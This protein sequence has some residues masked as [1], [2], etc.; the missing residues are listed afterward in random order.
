MRAV[1]NNLPA[2][3]AP[4]KDR[5]L[6][7]CLWNGASRGKES[8]L[9]DSGW[10]GEISA[11]VGRVRCPAFLSILQRFPHLVQEVAREAEEPVAATKLTTRL[12]I[13]VESLASRH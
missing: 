12:R 2:P 8:V 3:S 13:A 10:V 7:P 5:L 11:E 6:R 4:L 1:K 9:A